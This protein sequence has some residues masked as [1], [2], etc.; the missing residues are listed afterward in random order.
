MIFWVYHE[1][2]NCICFVNKLN[3]QDKD[4]DKDK[5]KCIFSSEFLE[6]KEKE[7]RIPKTDLDSYLRFKLIVDVSE[8]INSLIY[9]PFIMIFVVTIGRSTYFD[10][11]GLPLS[12]IVVFV[13]EVL[14]LSWMV[15]RLRNS[16]N[17][18]RDEI[19]KD[20][21]AKIPKETRSNL[22]NSLI[23]DIRNTQQGVYA[24]YMNHPLISAI[25]LPI[26]GIS[27]LHIF[28]YFFG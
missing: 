10:A 2:K 11:L 25:L 7:Y 22:I 4:K 19:L 13:F 27:G 20:Y 14:L 24:S 5:D 1:I 15:Y 28:E 17:S 3:K 23:E 6:K 12:L 8:S 18:V 9:L 21:E 16:A 26:G